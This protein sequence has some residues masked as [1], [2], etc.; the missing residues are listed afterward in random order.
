MINVNYLI[1]SFGTIANILN[2]NCFRSRVLVKDKIL[3]KLVHNTLDQVFAE[4][5]AAKHYFDYNLV[6]E[7]DY[8]IRY[9]HCSQNG[10]NEILSVIA[11]DIS[12]GDIDLSKFGAA[13]RNIVDTVEYN[14]RRYTTLIILMTDDYNGLN[15]VSG[16]LEFFAQAFG[17]DANDG[18]SLNN[19]MA[20]CK[21]LGI[22]NLVIK[23]GI[24]LE[25]NVSDPD[26]IVL[27]CTNFIQQHHIK[28]S[29]KDTE[30]LAGAITYIVKHC[31]DM[32][33]LDYYI[34]FDGVKTLLVENGYSKA[35][36]FVKC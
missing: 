18:N 16:L 27:S 23:D 11:F 5:E 22:V 21:S 17:F 35:K 13:N 34:D 10:K 1:D 15:F 14:G 7:P 33:A 9:T 19:I 3:C 24:S 12:E 6:V 36:T 31:D 20:F 8:D 4:D 30:A 26:L 29:D 25:I 28:L 32:Y 2:E